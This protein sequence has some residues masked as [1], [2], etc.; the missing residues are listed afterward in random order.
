[1][2]DEYLWIFPV[3]TIVIMMLLAV[4]VSGSLGWIHLS[5]K[6]STVLTSEGINAPSRLSLWRRMP[7]LVSA[8]GFMSYGLHVGHGFLT[9]IAVDAA[10]RGNSLLAMVAGGLAGFGILMSQYA[11]TVVLSTRT[12]VGI[13]R[14]MVCANLFFVV[15]ASILVVLAVIGV[16]WLD[17]LSVDVHYSGLVGKWEGHTETKPLRAFMEEQ[18]WFLGPWLGRFR[19][20]EWRTLGSVS[21]LY[22]CAAIIEALLFHAVARRITTPST[23]MR[24]VPTR[25]KLPTAFPE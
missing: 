11:K 17:T 6:M 20:I 1:M 25:E 19:N 4:I 9:I 8:L 24:K 23:V 22:G 18:S 5:K 14:A 13:R 15:H 2:W 10:F 16:G 21:F 12:R 3:H 7:P